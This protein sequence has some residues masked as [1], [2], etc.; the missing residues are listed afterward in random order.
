VGG[1]RRRLISTTRSQGSRTC[2]F[3]PWLPH[4]KLDAPGNLWF[5][6]NNIRARAR[7]QAGRTHWPPRFW[8]DHM[9]VSLAKSLG[10][11][12]IVAGALGT[13]VATAQEA[14]KEM[15]L[16]VFTSGALTLDKSI[17][18]N[19]ASGKVTIPVAFFLIRHPKGDA[20]FDCGNNDRIITD[21]S[22]W[23][24]FVGALD[25]VRTPDIA[26]D[27]AQQDQCQAVGYQ[28]RR[29]RAFP[30]GSCW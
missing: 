4:T 12:A 20:L 1:A 22:Y 16:Y 10:A 27:P 29:A 9:P 7:V 11:V 23:G 3:W 14:A 21:P 18:Q 30:R 17:I 15:R 13:T 5:L 6:D 8:E 28:V 24:P 2:A 26:I 25:P 19:G